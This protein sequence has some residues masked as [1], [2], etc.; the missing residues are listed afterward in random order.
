MVNK[1]CQAFI[2]FPVELLNTASGKERHLEITIYTSAVERRWWP[3][4]RRAWGAL[5]FGLTRLTKR[6]LCRR[7][8]RAIC[9]AWLKITINS[10]NIASD[11][12]I[13][14]V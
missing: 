6:L 3:G 12:T 13:T 14:T 5:R 4:W 8:D 11:R 9:A 10:A 1:V 7:C 2:G